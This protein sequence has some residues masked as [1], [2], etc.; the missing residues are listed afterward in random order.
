MSV[1]G[2]N[3]GAL[4][5][6]PCLATTSRIKSITARHPPCLNR[7]NCSHGSGIGVCMAPPKE[8]L[9]NH[10]SPSPD[11]CLDLEAPRHTSSTAQRALSSRRETITW[12]RV[13]AQA[14]YLATAALEKLS[15]LPPLTVLLTHTTGAR[16]TNRNKADRPCLRKSARKIWA[17]H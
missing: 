17:Q 6:A 10:A 9:S 7:F 2:S 14:R 1:V 15:S 5:R 11:R 16:G 4:G 13:D 12:H 3:R 8:M